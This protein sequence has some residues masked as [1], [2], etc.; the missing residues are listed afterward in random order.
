VSQKVA[1]GEAASWAPQRIKGQRDVRR[2]GAPVEEDSRV[3]PAGQG[4]S[5]HLAAHQRSS[6]FHERH[7]WGPSPEQRSSPPPGCRRA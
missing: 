1:Q 3:A 2:H 5:V 7:P 6:A 4:P